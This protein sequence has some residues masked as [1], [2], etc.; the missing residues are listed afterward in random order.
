MQEFPLSFPIFEL[1]F[2]RNDYLVTKCDDGLGIGRLSGN[3]AK[4]GMRLGGIGILIQDI[5]LGYI[6]VFNGI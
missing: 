4:A 6:L 5:V 3:N 2:R 1:E